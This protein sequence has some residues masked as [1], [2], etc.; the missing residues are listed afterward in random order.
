MTLAYWIIGYFVAAFLCWLIVAGGS[1]R[2][3]PTRG[4]DEEEKGGTEK[5]ERKRPDMI[6][7]VRDLT[8]E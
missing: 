3:T 4:T 2:C 6:K 7:F 8:G 5:Q 1:R